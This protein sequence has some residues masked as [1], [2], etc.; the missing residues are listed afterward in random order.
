MKAC[1]L[2]MTVIPCSPHKSKWRC[3]KN[4]ESEVDKK[5]LEKNEAKK[6]AD[7]NDN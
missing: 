6:G 1:A 2:V 3:Y 5:T 7:D 4:G